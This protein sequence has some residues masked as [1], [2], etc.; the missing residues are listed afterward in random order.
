MDTLLEKKEHENTTDEFIKDIIKLIADTVKQNN[1]VDGE[2]E[3]LI[4]L[5]DKIKKHMSKISNFTVSTNDITGKLNSD[6]NRLLE[7]TEDTVK[8]SNEGKYAIEEMLQVVKSLENEN[9]RSMESINELARKFSQVNEVV[10][11]INNIAGQTNLLALNAAIEAARAG[12]QGKGFSV[13]AGEIRKL[14][15]MTKQSTKNIDT[16]IKG[17]ENETKNVLDNS[18]KSNE[19]IVRG[20][21]VSEEA[22]DKIE[23]SLSSISKV[24]EE[25]KAV[26]ERLTE[27]NG[28]ITS[29]SKEIGQVEQVLI[30]TSSTILK[31]IEEANVVDR[32]L[33]DTIKKLEGYNK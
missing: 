4:E 8:K 18:N 21:K 12:E 13:V 20:V 27:Q 3:V 11:L 2:H 25:V 1:I 7:I 31:H 14:A 10:Q 30:T 26:I 6:G 32:Q 33:E 28:H 24:D 5:T 15:E 23:E 16:L 22:V 29:M 17:I 9:K 19:V